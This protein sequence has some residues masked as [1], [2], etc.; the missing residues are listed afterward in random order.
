MSKCFLLLLGTLFALGAPMTQAASFEYTTKTAG[1][2]SLGVYD[3]QG[4]LLRTLQSGKKLEVG[5]NTVE[6]DGK[7]DLGRDLPAGPYTLKGLVASL[8]WE[9]QLMVGNAGKPPYLNAD[10]SGGW[11]GV[12]GH[13][14]DAAVD[15]GGKRV[16]LLWKQEEGTP[17]LIKVDPA[18]GVGKFKLWGAHNSWS[19]G[20]TQQ[21]ATDGEYVYVANNHKGTNPGQ[22][23]ADGTSKALIWRVKADTGEF[24]NNWPGAGTNPL[25]VS[26]VPV[27]AL[28]TLPRSWEMYAHPEKRRSPGFAVNLCGLAVDKTHLYCALRVQER[29]LILD[30]TTGTSVKEVAI[31]NP[32]GLAMAPDGNLYVISGRDVVEV[33]PE[34]A[35]LGPI[36]ERG[37]GAPYDLCVDAKGNLWVSDQ[38]EAM[39]VKVFSPAGKLLQTVGKAGGRA[40]GGE[41]AKLKSD[42]LYPTG[43][44]VMADGTLYVGEDCAPKRVAIFRNRKWADEWI[45]PNASGCAGVDIADEGNPEYLYHLYVPH[46]LARYRVD[47]AKK[48]FVLDAVWGHFGVADGRVRANDICDG[49]SGGQVRHLGGKTF[50]CSFG[51]LWR[52]DGFNLTPCANVGWGLATDPKLGDVLTELA[53]NWKSKPAKRGQASFGPWQVAFHTWRDK[54]GDGGA[55]EDEMDWATPPGND[56]AEFT[57][58]ELTLRP[59]VAED[60]SIYAWGYR[61]PCLGLDAGGNPIYAWSKAERLPRRPMGVVADPSQP[62]W[63]N[64]AASNVPYDAPIDLPG[65]ILPSGREI[66]CWDDP[67]DGGVYWEA[68][69]EGKGKGL[70]WA[71]SGIFA[72]IGKTDK[73]GNWVWMAGSKAMAFAKPGQF[74]KPGEFA[75]VVKGLLFL[76]DWN[77]QMRVWDKDTGLYAGSLFADG[78]RGPVPDENL[79]SVEYNEAHVYVNRQNGQIYATGGDAEGMKLFRVTGVEQVERFSVPVTL[80]TTAGTAA[81][82]AAEGPEAGW[83]I[84]QLPAGI[85]HNLM[86]V[87]FADTEHG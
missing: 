78:Y 41:W 31:A 27:A 80:G 58:N 30:K 50:F 81:V 22:P 19:W 24:A 44:A 71:S 29:L 53:A 17:A 10:G 8:G 11:G 56:N 47:Y 72:R 3:Q 2:V 18:G 32:A 37:L 64:S 39:Q 40:L 61:L 55:Q 54:N 65:A 87:H 35:M 23:A 52:V 42:L 46:D 75:G 60:M 83:Q 77:G 68:D 51:S 16:Y 62:S 79:I 85:Y 86:A 13:V 66:N 26:E 69:V 59:Y 74:Y 67:A 1:A 6:W 82:P 5:K 12:W 4:R 14:L 49:R 34:G 73:Q 33:S 36:I 45:G 84:G 20:E 9:Y 38:G 28:P 43:P 63:G 76:T 48:S 57:H 7:D 70:G 15:S 21:V 25:T